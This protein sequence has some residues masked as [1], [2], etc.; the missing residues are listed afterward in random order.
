MKT[1][2]LEKYNKDGDAALVGNWAYPSDNSK[3]RGGIA[4]LDKANSGFT[5]TYNSRADF[6][7]QR[8]QLW[9]Q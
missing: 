8:R 3:Q 7:R 1:K 4:K 6:K 2:K 9:V 5:G